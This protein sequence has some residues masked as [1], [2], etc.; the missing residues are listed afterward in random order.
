MWKQKDVKY[1][2]SHYGQVI[3]IVTKKSLHIKKKI[4][5]VYPFRVIQ[6][7]HKNE[8]F[9]LLLFETLNYF[10]LQLHQHFL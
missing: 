10:K 6:S 8:Q 4:N 5:K 9:L 2:L 7:I 1:P 3:Y